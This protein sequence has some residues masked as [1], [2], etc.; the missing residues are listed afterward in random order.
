MR[1]SVSTETGEVSLSSTIFSIPGRGRDLTLSLDYRSRDAK[2][3]DEGTKSGDTANNFGQ[4]VIAFYDVFDTNGYWL[5]TGALRYTTDYTTIV[6]ETNI[7]SER[8]VFNGYLQYENGTS[9]LTSGSI[10]NTTRQKSGANLAMHVFGEGWSLNL[11]WL[12]IEGEKVYA[13]L[14]GGKTYQADFNEVNGLK[15]Y[16]LADITFTKDTTSGNGTDASAYKLY[17]FS[18]DSYYFSANGELLLE[19]DRF[20]N[21]IRYYWGD[22]NGKRLLTKVVDTVG[23]PLE[24][25]YSD[26]MIFFKTGGRTVRLVKQPIPGIADR[27]CLSAFID[28]AGREVRYKYTFP[29]AGFDA[30]SKTP[31]SNTYANLVEIRYPS[32]AST[33][34]VLDRSRKRLGDSGY[35]EYFKTVER[36]DRDASRTYNRLRYQYYN[37]PDGYP[38]Y[39]STNVDETYKYYSKVTDSNG[40]AT[41]YVYNWKHLM[42]LKDQ[43][44]DRLVSE[45]TTTYHTRYNLPI[46][47]STRNYNAQGRVFEK[48]DLYEYDQRGNKITENHPETPGLA[49]SDERKVYYTYDYYYNLLTGKRYKQDQD[50]TIEVKNT[51]SRDK[52]TVAATETRGGGKLLSSQRFTHDD[53]GNLTSTSVEKDPGEWYATR[54]EYSRDYKGAYLTGTVS[55]DVRDADGNPRDIRTGFTYDFNTGWRMS[56][57]DGNGVKTTF[58]YDPLGR[59]TRTDLADGSFRTIGYNDRDNVLTATNANGSTLIYDYDGLGRLMK[60]NETTGNTTLVRRDYD[61][62]GVLVSERDGNLNQRKLTY[63]K[64]YRVTG[65]THYDKNG[66]KLAE[67]HVGYNEAYY[68]RFGRPF[69]NVSVRKKGDERDLVANYYFDTYGRLAKQGRMHQGQEELAYGWYDYLGDSTQIKDYNGTTSRFSYDGLGRMTEATD[70][71]G[72]TTSYSYDG[73]GNLAATTDALQQTVYLDY[74]SRGQKTVVKTPYQ[75]GQYS[76]SK[77]YYDKVGN[78]VRTVDPEGYV[79]NNRYTDRYF[80]E[81]VEKVIN[82]KESNITRFEYDREGNLT[83]LQKGLNSWYDPDYSTYTYK[84][85]HLNRLVTTVDAEHQ[86]TRYEYDK[87]SNLIQTTDRNG[88]VTGFTYDGLNRVTKKINSRDGG[89]NSVETSYDLLGQVR[90]TTDGSGQT[91]YEYDDLGRLIYTNH[92]GGMRQNYAYDTASRISE[93]KMMQGNLTQIDLKY[94]YDQVGRMTAVNDQGKRFKYQYDQIGRLTQEQNG[95]NGTRSEYTY[96]PSGSVRSLIHY[97]ASE[98]VGS[99]E[100]QYDLRGN[101]VQKTEGPKTSKYYYD[102]LSRIKTA[103]LPGDVTQNYEYDDLNNIKEIAEIKGGLIEQTDYTYDRNSRLLLSETSSGDELKQQR[104]QYDKEGNQTYKEEVIKRSGDLIADKT[105]QFWYNGYNQQSRVQDPDGKY[106]EYTYNAAGLRTK[107]ENVTDSKATNYFYDRGNIVLESDKDYKVTA[108]NIRGLKLIYRET[109]DQALY[110]LHNAHGDVTKLLNDKGWVIKD[111]DYDPFGKEEAGPVNAFGGDVAGEVWRN[112]TSQIDNPFRYC[113]E[114]LDDET[115]NYYLRARYYDSSVMRFTQEDTVN[116][117]QNYFAY[118]SNNPIKYIDP[119]GHWNEPEHL[120]MSYNVSRKYFNRETSYKIA[121]ASEAFDT[122]YSPT[123]PQYN[124]YHFNTNGAAYQFQ[125]EL[126]SHAVDYQISHITAGGTGIEDHAAQ[127]LGYILHMEEDKTAHIFKYLS[128]SGMMS[129]VLFLQD[130]ITYEGQWDDETTNWSYGVYKSM[131]HD[132]NP[133]WDWVNE[134]WA[135]CNGFWDNS[136]IKN[137]MIN[138]EQWIIRFEIAVKAHFMSVENISDIFGREGDYSG[139]RTY[140]SHG[141][142]HAEKAAIVKTAFDSAGGGLTGAKAA[143]DAALATGIW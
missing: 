6:G 72:Q 124:A 50:T 10:V 83:Q 21:S 123:D 53:Y 95:V 49:G 33:D 9:L 48:I 13:S 128:M 94:E 85:D 84:Y 57:T 29:D 100:Y 30:V 135:R 81:A 64:L 63:D 118:C 112:E 7:G 2:T 25:S 136:R 93:M 107:K 45:E 35:M 108:K 5:R 1:E 23:R 54:F 142:S 44:T 102:A 41:R 42:F 86:A 127:I 105:Y 96:H 132:D 32:G 97:N 8:W 125:E 58:E 3:Y 38:S 139:M 22:V 116:R 88:V 66:N 82:E 126:L 15:D 90:Q 119:T 36:S 113:G 143:Q 121:S 78:L 20:N 131:G 106:F 28:P 137:G 111:Y 70:A 76:I 77:Y 46:R 4:T 52:K 117:D 59:M 134:E 60:V 34:Y 62:N 109:N 67:S 103:Q 138:D 19:S 140:A 73:M 69:F 12:N 101:Q 80:L 115:G 71:M 89:K 37:E 74:D 120:A 75:E 40:V 43:R 47:Y 51:L 104:F 65:V 122:L 92:G 99:Y 26:S 114:Y 98:I 61:D 18:G 24:I 17:Y 31:A 133:N 87:N 39:K 14:P 56:Q 79:T 68:D 11:P 141:S 91:Q 110:Y 55:Q 129:H 130:K 27:Y 16:E